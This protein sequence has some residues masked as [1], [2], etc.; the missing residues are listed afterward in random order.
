MGTLQIVLTEPDALCERD[1]D[2]G[3]YKSFCVTHIFI[4]NLGIFVVHDV[5]TQN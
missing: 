3:K 2:T 5:E 1:R 4:L